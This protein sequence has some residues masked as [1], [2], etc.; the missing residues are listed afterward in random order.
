MDRLRVHQ[1]IIDVPR[2]DSEPFVTS[3][4]QRLVDCDPDNKLTGYSQLINREKLVYRRLSDTAAE[5]V[6]LTDPIT[7]QSVTVSG[8]G[9]AI[10]IQLFV[11][12][13]LAEDYN[14]VV[15]EHGDVWED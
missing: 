3:A 5:T 13:W 14:S 11:N 1:I 15:D 4:V 10:L 6:T 7:Q 9:M 12:N 2:S 8:A